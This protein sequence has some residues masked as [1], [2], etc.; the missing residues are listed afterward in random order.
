MR[1]LKPIVLAFLFPCLAYAA[2]EIYTREMTVDTFGQLLEKQAEL[3]NADLDSKIRAHKNQDVARNN[4]VGKMPAN[5]NPLI[6]ADQKFSDKEPLLEAIW[7]PIGSEVVEINYLGVPVPVSKNKPYVSEVDGWML[8]EIF[9][10]SI[11]LV[12]MKGTRVVER[13]NIS[14]DW[15]SRNPN[16]SVSVLPATRLS[17][18]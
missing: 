7:G 5:A 15:V 12:K 8:E 2:D 6:A 11:S 17:Q 1:F 10:Y 18:E 9:P 13:K 4:V 16:S 14:L 3:M